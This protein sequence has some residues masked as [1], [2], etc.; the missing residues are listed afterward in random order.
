MCKAKMGR[1][2]KSDYVIISDE[3]LKEAVEN[4]ISLA[5][6][7]KYLNKKQAGG[8]QA[9]YKNRINRLGLNCDHFLGKGH[10][11]N[12]TWAIRKEPKDILIKREGYM[13]QKTHLLRRA[14]IESGVF[15]SSLKI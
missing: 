4:N 9:H 14:L 5:G 12:K 1:A 15:D 10:N 13:R 3:M 6:V 2:K 7:L 8:T 11:K